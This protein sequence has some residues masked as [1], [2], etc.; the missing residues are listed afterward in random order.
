MRARLANS[1]VLICLATVS[2]GDPE[3]CPPID[4]V[5]AGPP[6]PAAWVDPTSVDYAAEL[7]LGVDLARMSSLAPGLYCLDRSQGKGEPAEAGATVAVH[8]TGY[9][10][11]GEVFDSSRDR[12]PFSVLLGAGQVISGWELGLLGMRVGGTRL[13]VIPPHLAYGAQGAGDAIPPNAVLVF[14]LELVLMD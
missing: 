2:C 12:A 10:P 3:P 8:Y 11:D 7:G 14:E 4:A 6:P 13:L 1:L 9:L 5:D